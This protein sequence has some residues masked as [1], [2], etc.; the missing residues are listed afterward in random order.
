M[1][2]LVRLI[3][4]RIQFNISRPKKIDIKHHFIQDLV[5][6]KLVSISHI[7]TEKQLAGIF[8]KALD[9]QRFS[10]LRK[11]LGMCML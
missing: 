1:I 7:S 5:E 11:S 8:T 9:F 2:I 6:K 10:S 4:L 3:Y